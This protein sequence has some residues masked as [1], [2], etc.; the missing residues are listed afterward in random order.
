MQ[1]NAGYRIFLVKLFMFHA[2]HPLQR[3]SIETPIGFHSAYFIGFAPFPLVFQIQTKNIRKYQTPEAPVKTLPP[4]SIK[5]QFPFGIKYDVLAKEPALR[6][7][8]ASSSPVQAGYIRKAINVSQKLI[9]SSHRSH[10][11]R[12]LIQRAEHA[13]TIRE[14]GTVPSITLPQ[15][16]NHRSSRR[17]VV[18]V[19]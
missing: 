3:A 11:L 16:P 17:V 4:P 8:P 12:I 15:S 2:K 1:Q 18:T 10:H 14:K 6:P 13:R 19:L 9:R 5:A 7:L